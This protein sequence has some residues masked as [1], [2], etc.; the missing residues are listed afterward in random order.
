MNKRCCSSQ[1]KTRRLAS[2]LCPQA[3]L[4][5]A[6]HTGLF[7]I[8]KK[9]KGGEN[10]EEERM[11]QFTPIPSSPQQP[12]QELPKSRSCRPDPLT[13]LTYSKLNSGLSTLVSPD[14]FLPILS[15]LF[16]LPPHPS[17]RICCCY[18]TTETPGIEGKNDPFNMMNVKSRPTKPFWTRKRHRF[19]VKMLLWGFWL[20]C[21]F[22]P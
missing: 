2:G 1:R 18:R 8:Q 20:S 19:R 12:H 16:L 5:A 7:F 3:Y 9:K 17:L 11:R 6:K 10:S 4:E 13:I 22:H 21:L 15:S 14:R